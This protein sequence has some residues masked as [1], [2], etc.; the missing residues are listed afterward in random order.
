MRFVLQRSRFCLLGFCDAN[1]VNHDKVILLRSIIPGNHFQI[2]QLKHPGATPEHL[3]IV[4]LASD[5]SHEDQTLQW[6]YVCAG[7]D[8]L[9]GHSY[10][11]IELVAEVAQSFVRL[12][13]LA[14]DFLAELVPLTKNFS[15]DL[16]DIIS[17]AVA[18]RKD[19]RFRHVLPARK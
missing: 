9:H 16:D 10:T 11:R 2:F 14:G 19:Q 3:F 6:L 5:I 1:S 17:V 13:C 4:A 7:G 12:L 8:H 15:D 18:F